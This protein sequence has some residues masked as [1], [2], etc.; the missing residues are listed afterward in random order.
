MNNII[1]KIIH[2]LHHIW[3]NTILFLA[4]LVQ[5][6]SDN[7]GNSAPDRRRRCTGMSNIITPTVITVGGTDNR[8]FSVSDFHWIPCYIV[9]ASRYFPYPPLYTMGFFS[10]LYSLVTGIFAM[11]MKIDPYKLR[12]KIENED[13]VKEIG[14][15]E[16]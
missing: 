16:N 10:Q 13:F 2:L 3:L 12:R 14:V 4:M 8:A 11:R 5:S 1:L 6:A 7:T 15:N 9:S